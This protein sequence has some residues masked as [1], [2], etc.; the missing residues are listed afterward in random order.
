MAYGIVCSLSSDDA[1]PSRYPGPVNVYPSEKATALTELFSS[2]EMEWSTQP[3]PK[4]IG[5]RDA[6][7]LVPLRVKRNVNVLEGYGTAQLQT[8]Q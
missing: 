5:L 3:A 8:A 2:V 4:C 6:Y 7:K 1:E